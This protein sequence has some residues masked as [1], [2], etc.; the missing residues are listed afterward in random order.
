MQVVTPGGEPSRRQ[1]ATE[2]LC[3]A[4]LPRPAQPPQ[5]SPTPQRRRRQ[6]QSHHSKAE[7]GRV[8]SSL[9]YNTALWGGTDE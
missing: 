6:P 5:A 7:T 8:C 3:A 9:R 1:Q 4:S 2:D